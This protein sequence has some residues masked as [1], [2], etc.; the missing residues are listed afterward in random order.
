ML[1][2]ASQAAAIVLA[3]LL[4]LPQAVHGGARALVIEVGEASPP[5]AAGLASSAASRMRV[6]Q[7]NE[8]YEYYCSGDCGA[9]V[10][11]EKG[12][13]GVVYMGG[14]TDV[15][16]AFPWLGQRSAGGQLLVLR[17]GPSGDDK[18]DPFILG[19]GGHSSVAT[20]ILKD[21][22]AS[23]SAAPFIANASSIF[24]AGGDQ[25]KYWRQWQGTAVQS[26]VQRRLDAGGV[27]VGGTSAGDAVLG[28]FCNCALTG[29][30]TSVAALADPYD[31][32]LSVSGRFLTI[33]GSAQPSDT[34]NDM[35]FVTRDRAGRL[36]AMMT[37]LLE[38]DR[39]NNAS[40]VVHG[41]G[42][43]EKTAILALP[44]GVVTI[45][46]AGTAYFFQIT[47][48]TW[49]VCE[50]GKPLSVAQVHAYRLDAATATNQSFDLKSWRGQGGVPYMFTIENGAY[51]GGPQTPYGPAKE[52]QSG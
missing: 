4:A 8:H 52:E 1:A 14:G 44:S 18:Y 31:S 11:T 21:K 45:A 27:P 2:R 25:S 40:G 10:P 36:L 35:H 32:E 23:Q 39:V 43:D 6:Q 12:E 48:D 29:S 42:V 38:D 34:I 16:A 20:L 17:T 22:T 51:V 9:A 46:G 5:A 49:R 26:A 15:A 50:Q 19:L 47:A 30:V 3:M 24:F 13:G 41:I 33:P 37:R 7:K 28:S